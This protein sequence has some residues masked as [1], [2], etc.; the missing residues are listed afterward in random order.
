MIDGLGLQVPQILKVAINDN[1]SNC[2]KAI[3]VSQYLI[4]YLCGIHTLQLANVDTFKSTSVAGVSMKNVLSK[5]KKLANRVKL[6]GP[7]TLALKTACREIN[8]PYT[9][10]K[11]PNKTR[12]NSQHTNLKSVIKL[13]PALLKLANEDTS[14]DWAPRML[15]P[16]EWKLAEQAAIILEQPLLVTKAWE[17][18]TTPTINLVVEQLFSM[19]MKVEAVLRTSVCR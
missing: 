6:S 4:Q 16:S 14:G 1:A 7:A 12:W 10:L 2:K 18:E 13:K 17:A 11:N 9:S 19:K 8:L 5:C 15:T 3:R